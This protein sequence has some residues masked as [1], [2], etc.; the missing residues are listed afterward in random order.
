MAAPYRV[1]IDASNQPTAAQNYEHGT[2]AVTGFLAPAT[3]L[4]DA[5]TYLIIAEE[6]D[7]NGNPAGAWEVYESVW[8]D[9]TTDFFA[10]TTFRDSSTGSAIDWSSGTGINK[11]PRIRV[12]G[13]VGSDNAPR[14]VASANMSGASSFIWSTRANCDYLCIFADL[15]VSNDG[16]SIGIVV[17]DDGGATYDTG[18]G[19]YAHS[20]VTHSST[21][22]VSLYSQSTTAMLITTTW[23]GNLDS[24]EEVGGQFWVHG[25]ND[26]GTLTRINGEFTTR[27]NTNVYFRGNFGGE[28][29]TAQADDHIA[30]VPTAGTMSGRISVWEFPMTGGE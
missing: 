29:R 5:E 3:Q 11:V 25:A 1:A 16:I 27:T 24:T 7:G 4:T 30:I 28:R 15:D 9:S 20:S 26:S 21:V 22:G 13:R 10:R 19:D 6:I 23:L 8:N 18:A 14:R 2:T 12:L 17:S